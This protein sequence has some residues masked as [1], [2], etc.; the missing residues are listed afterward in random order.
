MARTTIPFSYD[1]VAKTLHWLIAFA[2]IAMLIIGWTMTNIGKDNPWRFGLFQWHKSIGI[3]I[4]LLSLIRLVW[5]LTHTAPPLPEHMP[6][7]EKFAAKATHWFFYVLIIG[8]P[9]AGWVLISSSPISLPT[10]LYGFIH[11]PD[12]PGLADRWK[13]IE[14]AMMWRCVFIITA[15]TF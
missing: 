12:V 9:L 13:A 2:I 5:R 15:P 10:M 14:P 3:T 1:N 8:M 6:A 4:L 7:W 11:W